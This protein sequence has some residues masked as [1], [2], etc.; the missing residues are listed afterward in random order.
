LHFEKDLAIAGGLFVLAATGAG[1]LSLERL[2]KHRRPF[3]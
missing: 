2:S 3:G 1:A